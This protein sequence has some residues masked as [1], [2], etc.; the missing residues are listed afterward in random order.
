LR[1]SE[2]PPR[3][4]LWRKLKANGAPNQT[5]VNI[6]SLAPNAKVTVYPWREP[7][8]LKERTINR[9]RIFLKAHQPVT[10]SR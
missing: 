4:W 9:V 8:E 1:L 5:S 7:L 6:G 2:G 10:A 3:L